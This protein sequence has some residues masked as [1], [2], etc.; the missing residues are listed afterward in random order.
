MRNA[1]RILLLSSLALAASPV[2]A[3]D[4]YY[5]FG[6]PDHDQRRD[7]LPGNG[8]MY[9]APTAA[10][11]ML[12]YM[13]LHGVPK[14]GNTP[15]DPAGVQFGLANLHPVHSSRIGWLGSYMQTDAAEGTKGKWASGLAA[16]MGQAGVL[17]LVLSYKRDANFPSPQIALS[18]LRIGAMVS[19]C[20]GRYTKPY[21]WDKERDGGHC[22]TMVGVYRKDEEFPVDLPFMPDFIR[23]Y[24]IYYNDPARD[25]GDVPGRLAM[26]SAFATTTRETFPEKANFGGVV[27]TLYGIGS[28]PNSET[29]PDPAKWRY[30][31]IDGYT[32][33]KPFLLLTNVVNSDN[34]KLN[35]GM[36]YEKKEPH[37]Q[38]SPLWFE[39]RIGEE[40]RAEAVPDGGDFAFDPVRP[41]YLRTRPDSKEIIESALE[42]PTRRVAAV[43][44]E[45][46]LGI[47]FGGPMQDLFVMSERSIHKLTRAGEWTKRFNT[48][49]PLLGM[50]FD[51]VHKRLLVSLPSRVQ[52]LNEDL[53]P[54]ATLPILSRTSGRVIMRQDPVTGDILVLRRGLGLPLSRI[55]NTRGVYAVGDPFVPSGVLAPVA[56]DFDS[57]GNVIV[58]DQGLLRSLGRDGRPIDSRWNNVPAGRL[59]RSNSGFQNDSP[60]NTTPAWANIDNGFEPLP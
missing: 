26:Q 49:E 46:V 35:F 47:T 53:Q 17:G 1:K 38:G 45:N 56:F 43:A 48:K 42:R 31:Y 27:T 34:I 40:E 20:Y 52:V 37:E 14:A 39:S 44:P 6:V 13:R 3:D 8:G 60:A 16:Y 29:E 36:K 19:F 10:W 5:L 23:K 33:L 7:D 22:V 59:I 21:S 11:N 32:I 12:D 54:I 30:A 4:F 24:T 50:V 51:E 58:S 18:W 15:T 25:E 57:F 28:K 2:H 9:C 41:V 55:R